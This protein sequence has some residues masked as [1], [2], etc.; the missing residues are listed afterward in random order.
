MS[1]VD[2]VVAANELAWV[3]WTAGAPASPV[4]PWLAARGL[5]PGS[6]ARAG[7]ALGWAGPG[8]QDLTELLARHRVPTQVAIDAGLVRRA[9]SGRTY[10]G[11][12][13]RIIVAVRDV[14]GG[15]ILGFMG[16][17]CDDTDARAPK[18]LNSPGNA[19]YRK[20]EVLVGAWEARQQLRAARDQI[21]ALVVC[22][23]PFDVISVATTG[24][25]VAVAPGGTAMTRSQAAWITAL[26]RAFDLP[27]QLAYDGDDAGQQAQWRAWDLLVDTGVP[28]LRLADIPDH[29]DPGSLHGADLAAALTPPTREHTPTR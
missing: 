21:E 20:G 28:G 11:F 19:A 12:R 22:E 16:R 24:R 26:A 13:N 1:R 6:V 8:W 7:V 4:R 25:W 2:Q 5:D 18:Y 10:D 3:A 14:I 9:E 15:R 23:G 29:A 27:V 17:R